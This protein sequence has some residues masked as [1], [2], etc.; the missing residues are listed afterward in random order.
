L[1]GGVETDDYGCG[2]GEGVGWH[3]EEG[4]DEEEEEHGRCSW[5]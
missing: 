5:V 2:W 3:W 4:G 1:E